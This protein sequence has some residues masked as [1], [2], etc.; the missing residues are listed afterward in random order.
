MATATLPIIKLNM[1]QRTA[2]DYPRAHR[3][4]VLVDGGGPDILLYTTGQAQVEDW[5][6]MERVGIRQVAKVEVELPEIVWGSAEEVDNSIKL[7]AMDKAEELG[8][9][10]VPYKN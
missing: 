9:I 2:T 3:Q 5:E 4:Y 10:P 8:L 1:H 6:R 7:A